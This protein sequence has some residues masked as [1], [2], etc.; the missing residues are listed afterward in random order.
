MLL[1]AVQISLLSTRICVS[2]VG[3]GDSSRLFDREHEVA[4]RPANLDRLTSLLMAEV[5]VLRDLGVERI[6]VTAV[7][8]LRGT[9]LIRLL[10]RVSTAIG[11]G[12]IR[13]PSR[14]ESAASAFLGATV[15]G[16]FD[17][18]ETVT[19]AR[20]GETSVDLAVGAPGAMPDWFG[21]RPIGTAA[22]ARKARISDP[23]R[24]DQLEAASRGAS[25]S[26]AS[27]SWPAGDRACAVSSLAEQVETLC[28]PLVSSDD[29]RRGLESVKN[30]RVDDISARFE[31]GPSEARRVTPALVLHGALAEAM[32]RPV[33]PVADDPVAGRV[34]L[35]EIGR[36]LA[37]REPG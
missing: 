37:D 3:T 14:R 10:G 30:E 15:P 19:V 31:V 18:G 2:D 12:E 35:A 34:W 25:R 28:G 27:L 32:C 29:A 9:R 17:P 26:I 11:S 23:P 36:P 20:I 13:I 24:L 4:A 6:E 5:E 7:P 22:I 1:G 21:S 33:E 8:E 16:D